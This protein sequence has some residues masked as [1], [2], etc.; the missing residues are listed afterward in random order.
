MSNLPEPLPD[1][2]EGAR[3]ALTNAAALGLV[4]PAPAGTV[5]YEAS[6][7]FSEEP[8]PHLLGFY[9]TPDD[10]RAAVRDWVLGWEEGRQTS[11]WEE[12][13]PDLAWEEASQRWLDERSDEVIIAT[14]FGNNNGSDQYWIRRC[15]IQSGPART[16]IT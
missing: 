5:M 12:A 7:T 3:E 9:C 10:A 2:L 14:Y 8:S 16:R 15:T 4:L 11:A 6:V 13:Y 1:S